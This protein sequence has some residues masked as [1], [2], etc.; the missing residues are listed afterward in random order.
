VVSILVVFYMFLILFAI[1][2]AMRGWAKEILVAFSVILAMAL[3]AILETLIPVVRDFM[4]RDPIIQF[5]SRTVILTLVGLF[6]CGLLVVVYGN[7]E[8]PLR[9]LHHR[10]SGRPAAGRYRPAHRGLLAPG[11]AGESA[12]CLYRGG[13]RLYFCDRGVHLMEGLG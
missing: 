3:I 13:F 2:G 10:P 1:I 6:D 4:T 8:L 9:A 7:G 12:Q 5:W 11:L